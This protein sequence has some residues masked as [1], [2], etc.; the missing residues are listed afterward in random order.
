MADS[1]ETVSYNSTS[2]ITEDSKAI[3]VIKSVRE[4]SVPEKYKST[5]QIRS[6]CT[7]PVCSDTE[8]RCRLVLSYVLEG[9]K[10]VDSSVKKDGE[11]PAADPSTPIPLK[12]ED[13]SADRP[14]CVEKQMELFLH[15][16]GLSE[17]KCSSLFGIVPGAWQFK[18]KLQ[19]I[20]KASKAYYV[21]SDAAVSLQ[22][23]GRALRY[24]KLALQ[25]HDAYSGLCT[26]IV[27]D[28]MLLL[29]QYL[30]LC[31]DVQ[32]MLAQNASNRAAYYEEYSYQTRDDQEILHSLQRES[33]CQGFSWATDLINDL[34]CQLSVSCRC[35]ESASEILTFT[36]PQIQN[37]EQSTQVLKRLGNIR[38]EIGVFYMN[39]AAA[40]Q[41]ERLGNKSV[42]SAEQDLLQKSFSSFEKGI[43]NFDSIKDLTNIALL[44]CNMGRL[45]RICAQ[46]HSSSG[47]DVSRGE[48]SSDEA[49]YYN[50]AVEYYHNAL[51]AL[52]K[53]ETHQA[54][55]DSVYW[56]L[57][58]TYFTMATLLQDYAPL[59]RKAQEQIEK[60]VTEAMMKSLQYCDVDTV[61]A[62]QPLCQYRAAT[63]H[64]RL[65]SMYHSCLRNQVG[66]EHLRKQHR[67]Q[68]DLHYSKAVKLFQFLKDAPCELLRVQ[69]ERVA[70]A[71]FQMSSQNSS[72]GKQ[73]T[74][75]GALDIMIKTRCALVVIHKELLSESDQGCAHGSVASE[76]SSANLSKEEILKLVNIFESRLSFLLLQ[77]VKLLSASKKK[78]SVPEEEASLRTYKQVYSNLLRATTNTSATLSER[79]SL[80]IHLLDQLTPP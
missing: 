74:L 25:C 30:T 50:K 67:G 47:T 60:K 79:L 63:I 14:E 61:C 2:E 34:G 21:L 9:L 19:L 33:S 59:S 22:K 57:S 68:A 8:E 26:S 71:E 36:N 10:C 52:D 24:I 45:M 12:Y 51:K 5:H 69:L 46:A 18:I 39:Q 15:K 64:H 73:K 35:Y 16:M 54:V 53:R 27:P 49:H 31:G 76:D 13:D 55:W 6:S 77:F 43:S 32:L 3:A 17:N 66:D 40:L 1:D 70:F 48:F 7:F 72:A 58:T 29:C 38:N 41:S 20:L 75:C 28:V 37:P 11:L 4:L 42:S 44:L 80:L 56:E 23:Y 78:N 62:R 65:A